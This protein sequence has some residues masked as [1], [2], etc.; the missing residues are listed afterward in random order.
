MMKPI[1]FTIHAMEQLVERGATEDEVRNAI[2]HG[3]REP[4]KRGRFTFRLNFQF[5]AEWQ[6]KFYAIKQDAPVAAEAHNE[7]VVVTVYTFYF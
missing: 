3:V 7:I 4:A 2:E 6:G 1:R 5:N